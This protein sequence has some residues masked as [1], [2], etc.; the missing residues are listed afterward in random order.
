VSRFRLFPAL[1]GVGGCLLALKGVAILRD[2]D[3]PAAERAAAP[4]DIP[5]FG[6]AIARARQNYV[7]PDPDI[8]GSAPAKPK[9]DEA[10][11]AGG[12]QVSQA[13]PPDVLDPAAPKPPSPAERA[14]LE[15][16]GE[17]REEIEGRSR[18]METREALL[19]A[20]EKKLD[21]RVGDLRSLEERLQGAAENR[22]QSQGQAIK[23][24]VTM[25]ETMKPK[26]AARVFE[27]LDHKVLIPVVQ[28][29][30][31]RKMSE[32][33]AA[34]SPESA[35]KLTIALV[36]RTELAGD[37]AAPAAGANELPRLER[38]PAPPKP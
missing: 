5:S 18:E 30:N 11:G 8:T 28:K 13:R 24:L 17:R 16:L 3:W 33:L 34:M 20:A 22:E 25:Y 2:L 9:K 38:P 15:R 27:R 14:I 23:N 7:P 31:P 36:T 26:D 12:T 29:M 10:A 1:I 4:G 6:R 35:E 37:P 32:I 19:R 21:S